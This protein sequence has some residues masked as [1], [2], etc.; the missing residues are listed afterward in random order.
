MRKYELSASKLSKVIV[1]QTD[2]QTDTTD[3]GLPRRYGQKQKVLMQRR[4]S[5]FFQNRF[6]SKQQTFGINNTGSEYRNKKK[7]EKEINL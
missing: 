2:R 6:T 3:I 1:R 5:I 7:K 4:K